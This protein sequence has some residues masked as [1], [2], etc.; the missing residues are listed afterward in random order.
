MGRGIGLSFWRILLERVDR[1][2]PGLKTVF[3]CHADPKR[4]VSIG[5][6]WIVEFCR[7][8][9]VWILLRQ[10]EGADLPLEPTCIHRQILKPDLRKWCLQ[11]TEIDLNI[12][13]NA[14][15]GGGST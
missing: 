9:A 8:H 15:R 4:V 6:Q 7:D 13:G 3:R 2:D 11:N 14:C 10:S 1:T 5:L 12:K